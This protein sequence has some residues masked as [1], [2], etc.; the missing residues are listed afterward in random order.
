M[1]ARV[2]KTAARTIWLTNSRY[3][4]NN[5]LSSKRH[6]FN[7][8]T[9]FAVL[10]TQLQVYSTTTY[11]PL[12]PAHLCEKR[13]VIDMIHLRLIVGREDRANGKYTIGA[14]L[15]HSLDRFIFRMPFE[16]SHYVQIIATKAQEERLDA[17]GR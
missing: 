5:P 15:D 11:L 14:F 7:S 2:G 1:S 12:C 8:R 16:S 10:L 6:E 17:A 9:R 4:E 13:I 3:F